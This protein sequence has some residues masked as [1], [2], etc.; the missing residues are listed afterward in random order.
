MSKL[1][2]LIGP[3]LSGK[4]V[5]CEYLLK[6]EERWIRVSRDDFRFM[7]F[8][9][10]LNPAG[11]AM[12]TKLVDAAIESGLRAGCNVVVDATH[13]R[14]EYIQHYVT[15]FNHL[16][17]IEFK[18]FD[19]SMEN[20]LKRNERRARKLSPGLIRKFWEECFA[21]MGEIEEGTF[22]LDPIPQKSKDYAIPYTPNG[23]PKAI[24]FDVDGTLALKGGRNPFDYEAAIND[25]LNLPL[26]FI[27]EEVA[28]WQDPPYDEY[29][30]PGYRII[31]LSGREDSG[32]ETL[33]TW[34]E[35]FHLEYSELYMRKTGDH[36]KDSVVKKEIYEREIKGKYDV[37]CWF[38]DRN[39][40]VR[41]VRD[42]L[43]INCFQVNDGDF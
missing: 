12:I 30:D 13:C 32:K 25:T 27:Y 1:K 22:S 34:L 39:Q 17:D 38:D 23:L 14:K 31:I 21:L 28:H 24:I 15:K 2:I 6:I 5:Y 42:E 11:E 41:M 9:Q 35:K 29:S 3:P 40:V 26:S 43:K 4:S 37:V 20:L 8:S 19:V 33:K 18:L 7:Q 16:A 10:M 36:R